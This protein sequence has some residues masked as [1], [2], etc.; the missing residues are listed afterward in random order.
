MNSKKEQQNK[1][2]SFLVLL[3]ATSWTGFSLFCFLFFLVNKEHSALIYD[4]SN[5]SLWMRRSVL[6]I[7]IFIII[8]DHDDN[9]KNISL[10]Q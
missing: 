6:I 8:E 7:E 1:S 10:N 4:F 5:R 3:A 2:I 9:H